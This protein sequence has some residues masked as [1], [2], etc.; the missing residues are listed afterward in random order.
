MVEAA[1]AFTMI[2]T[3]NE[4]NSQIPRNEKPVFSGA[5]NHGMT[6]Y[7]LDQYGMLPHAEWLETH[8]QL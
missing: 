3:I 4:A 2:N 7:F 6:F 1:Q 8:H 5:G